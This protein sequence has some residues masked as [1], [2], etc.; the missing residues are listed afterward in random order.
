MAMRLHIGARTAGIAAI[1]AV[2]LVGA[3]ERRHFSTREKAFYA[4]AQT[5]E[6]VSPGLTITVTGA[7]ISAD[8]TITAQYTLTDPTGLPLDS[9][10]AY[11][12]GTISTSFVA[13]YIPNGQEQYTAYTTKPAAGTLIAAVNQPGADS[14]GTTTA[15]GSGA[16]QYV[17]VT[18]APLGFD[19]TATNTIGVYGSRNL[20]EYA[21]PT[22]YASATFNFVPNGAKVTHTRDVIETS[23]CNQCHEQ[24][25]AHGGSRRGVSLCVMCHT[26]QNV[27]PNTGQTVDF[28]SFIHRIHMG[29]SLPSV[30]AGGT[31]EITNSFGVSNY[32][33]VIDPAN[34]QRCEVCHQQTTGAAQATAFLTNPTRVACGSCHDNVNFATGANHPGGF[35]TDDTQCSD[36]H[37]PQGERPFDASIM[38][39]HV[40]A[41]DTATFYPQNPDTLISGINL[42][43]TGV[44]NTMAGSAPVVS[45]TLL[46]NSNN[47]IALRALSSLSFTMAGPTTD[48]GYTIFGTSTT[49]PGYVTESAMTAAKCDTK[50]NCTYSFTNVVPAKST[51]TYAIGGEARRT[52]TVL[53]GTT[54]SQPVEYGAF[55]PVSYF[56]V[57][58]SPVETR[59]T[60]VQMTN[61]NTCHVALSEHGTLRS[62]V[63]YCVFCHNPSNTDA[64]TRATATVAADKAAPPQGI[65][66]NLLVHRIHDGVNVTANGGQPYIVVGF[67]GS[68]NDFSGVLF[69]GLSPTGTAT[70]LENCAFCH[71][72]S[73]E[74]NDLSL[75]GLHVVTDPQGLI[76]PVQPFSSAC[77]GCH[78]DIPS[79]SHF[80]S[81]S[82]SL[83]ESCA[84]CHGT[85]G[86][87]AVDSVHAQF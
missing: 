78:V 73:S 84:V 23:S 61:C 49:T 81:N 11:T 66:F 51:G 56:S 34:A 71:V 36:C 46:D 18:K 20:T 76:N 17:F 40:V 69:P 19:T 32:S 33:T 68:H 28:K 12:P 62:N 60:I 47:P 39:A 57:D 26:P 85:G 48:F 10:G 13:G 70:D 79:G 80:L 50:G 22:N 77:S 75:T 5:V 16:Y 31:F 2:S 30:V 82:N 64:T 3:Q 35:Q 87:F 74:Q 41:T 4:D 44:T 6:F 7:T 45:F 37:V 24:L 1:V 83:G 67:G 86:A 63:Q 59:R 42:A 72:N 65:N 55:N 21:V 58:G 54:S 25:S 27:D 38:G 15:L 8:G 29:S 9:A 43:I 52:E 14:G 53:A